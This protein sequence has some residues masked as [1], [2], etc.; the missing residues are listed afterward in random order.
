MAIRRFCREQNRAHE[1]RLKG[2]RHG[3]RVSKYPKAAPAH[4]CARDISTSLYVKRSRNFRPFGVPS[5]ARSDRALQTGRPWPDCN[6]AHLL[7]ATLTGY[8]SLHSATRRN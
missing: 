5:V 8:S 3:R 1:V 4:P 7:C 2:T 6:V